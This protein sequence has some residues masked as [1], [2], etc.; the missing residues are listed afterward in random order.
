MKNVCPCID[1]GD[2]KEERRLNEENAWNVIYRPHSVSIHAFSHQQQENIQREKGK[3]LWGE[4]S[5]NIKCLAL[6]T[7]AIIQDGRFH[8]FVMK[9]WWWAHT[10]RSIHMRNEGRRQASLKK[11]GM[12]ECFW[13]V[14][15]AVMGFCFAL[16]LD[17]NRGWIYVDGA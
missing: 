12:H 5:S 17:I 1:N 8:I 15:W 2:K 7:V 3:N 13:C 10:W 16:S 9:W 4:M 14:Y 6:S 11:K